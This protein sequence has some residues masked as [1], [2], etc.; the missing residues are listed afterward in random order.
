MTSFEH[1]FLCGPGHPRASWHA[2]SNPAQR[3][4][5]TMWLLCLLAFIGANVAI[6]F[7]FNKGFSPNDTTAQ[8]E[9]IAKQL[10]RM[11]TIKPE[12][13][14]VI[15]RIISLPRYD[16]SRVECPAVLAEHNRAVRARLTSMLA[17][18]S[19]QEVDIALSAKPA[20]LRTRTTSNGTTGR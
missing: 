12:V 9:Q 14:Q 2:P 8:M 20:G 17:G 1:R 18:V 10:E 4:V 6:I 15:E 7:L 13:A 11:K 3:R 16:C 19:P 5:W